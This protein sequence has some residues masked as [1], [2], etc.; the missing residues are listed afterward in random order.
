VS[1]YDEKTFEAYIYYAH[2]IHFPHCLT[3]AKAN[4]VFYVNNEAYCKVQTVYPLRVSLYDEKTFEAYIYYAHFIHF[5]HCLTVAKANVVFYVNNEA[6]C[7]VQTVYPLRVS[8]YDE[9]TNAHR[10]HV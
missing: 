9:K 8:L 6:Y 4:V 3:V 10:E 2:F 5:P 1:L 7:K